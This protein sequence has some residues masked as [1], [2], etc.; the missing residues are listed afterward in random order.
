MVC[1]D[2]STA[3]LDVE[4]GRCMWPEW[5]LMKQNFLEGFQGPDR[6]AAN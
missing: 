6:A 3:G 5:L 1:K 4:A 2:G